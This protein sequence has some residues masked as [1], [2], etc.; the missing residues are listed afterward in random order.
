MSRPLPTIPGEGPQPRVS[1]SVAAVGAT[2]LAFVVVLGFE[3]GVRGSFSNPGGGP[4]PSPSMPPR[5]LALSY[6]GTDAASWLPTS[7]RLTGDVAYPTAPGGQL[8]R[9][10]D[11]D[12]T[13]W[14]WRP[15]GPDSIDVSSH[16]SPVIRVPARGETATGRVGARGYYTIWEALFGGGDG[17]VSMAEVPCPSSKMRPGQPDRP[18]ASGMDGRP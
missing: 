4:A 13:Q 14:E 6:R 8:Y 7:V 10:I 11:Q 2:L 1:A 5:C 18:D 17:Q 3:T 12:G 16:H 9:A 15:A